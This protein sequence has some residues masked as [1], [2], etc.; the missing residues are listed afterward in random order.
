MTIEVL[1][2]QFRETQRAREAAEKEMH[3]RVEALRLEAQTLQAE[4]A[5]T[6]TRATNEVHAA[7]GE[8]EQVS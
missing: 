4:K 8:A 2:E 3:D 7:R 1:Q 5:R 6:V